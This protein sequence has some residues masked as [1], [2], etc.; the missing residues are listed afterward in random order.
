MKKTFSFLRSRHLWI[1]LVVIVA[2]L[3]IWF[4]GSLLSFGGMRPCAS[5]GIRLT[6]IALIVVAWILW[7]ADWS[8]S[9]ATVALI[10]LAIWYAFPLMTLAGKPLFAPAMARILAIVGVLLVYT[11]CMTIR[12]WRR[13]R[14]SPSQLRR[15]LRLG[16]RDDRTVATSRLME[17]E[18]M[19]RMA[20]AQMKTRRG[21]LRGWGRLFQNR[22]YLYDLPWYVV[23]GSK[24]AGKTTALLNAGLAFPLDRPLQRAL[25]PDDARA[26][27]G[28]RGSTP[29]RPDDVRP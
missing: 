26:L 23:L 13:M 1:V 9:I 28:W 21:G 22:T 11:V 6:L 27:P 25:A 4:A 20:I 10:C 7:L 16:R 15:L 5:P 8:V 29:L 19:A 3:V 14:A 17:I 2:A 18:R 24:G 12:W